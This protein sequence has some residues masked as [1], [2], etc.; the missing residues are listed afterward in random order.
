MSTKSNDIEIDLEG[1]TAKLKDMPWP[2]DGDQYWCIDGDVVSTYH[3]VDDPVD[4]GFKKMH[5]IYR[6]REAA[7]KAANLMLLSNAVIRAC[8]EVDPDF[9]PNWSNINE[10]KWSVY[11]SHALKKWTETPTVINYDPAHV[12]T[13]EKAQ[14]VCALLNEWGVK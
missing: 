5:N 3:W 9:E 8:L 1:D 11:Y 2:S 13:Q 6:T 4:Q 7:E 14:K 10:E 12:S